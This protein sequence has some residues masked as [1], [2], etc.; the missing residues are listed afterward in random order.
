MTAALSEKT[1][2]FTDRW[3]ERLSRREV[4]F[5]I[6][7][8][9][10]L[11][12]IAVIGFLAWKVMHIGWQDVLAH[13]PTQPGFYILFF[14]IFLLMPVNEL[15]VY[16]ILWQRPLLKSFPILIRKRIY[17]QAVMGYSG[18]AYFAFW[19][20]QNLNIPAGQIFSDIKDN[21]ILSALISNSLTILLL[22]VFFFSGQ[23]KLVTDADPS[24]T[25]YIIF[26]AIVTGILVPVVIRF[27]HKILGLASRFILILLS[28]H[29]ARLLLTLGLQVLQMSLVLEGVPAE[30]WLLLFTSH[31]VMTRIPFLPN[32]DLMFV[33]LGVSLAGYFNASPASVVGMFVALG[34]LSQITNLVLYALTSFSQHAPK[35]ISDPST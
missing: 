12:M 3:Q 18:E 21:N 32:V 19:A 26:A 22:M 29:T 5:A 27:R 11:I 10:H 7:G 17:N 2:T 33:G 1:R 13:L 28:L 9:R 4:Q 16:Q 34:A 31:M 23:L 6:K 25:S 15:F 30:V 8:L 14:M 20:K 35:Q 24:V